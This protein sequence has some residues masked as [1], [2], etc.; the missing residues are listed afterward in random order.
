LTAA[1]LEAAYVKQ[2]VKAREAVAKGMQ[3][4][5]AAATAEE[6]AAIGSRVSKTVKALGFIGLTWAVVGNTKAV[7]AGHKSVMEGVHDTI[8]PVLTAQDEKML[9]DLL[10]SRMDEWIANGRARNDPRRMDSGRR[11]CNPGEKPLPGE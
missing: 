5:A 1:E 10:K 3:E 2:V 4:A 11:S 7:F 8:N 9:A 6:A